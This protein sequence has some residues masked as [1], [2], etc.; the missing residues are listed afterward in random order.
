M[1]R[2]DG[3]ARSLA[4]EHAGAGWL[5]EPL[6]GG[7]TLSADQL[8]ECVENVSIAFFTLLE[9]LAPQA[10]AAFLTREVFGAG[11][12]EI[13]VALGKSETACRQLV[14]RARLQLR[15]RRAR[16]ALSK[17]A[18][19][20]LLRD[21]AS[22]S[23]HA[24]LATLKSMLAEDAEL[25][26]D[27]GRKAP[28]LGKPLQGGERIAQLYLAAGR[29]HGNALRTR[30]APINGEWGFLRFIDG[31]LESVQS[32]ETDGTRIVRI[33][34]QRDPGKLARLASILKNR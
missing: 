1:R 23:E 33:R 30:L 4:R 6:A 20:R 8:L 26:G 12:G 19:L 10:R 18:H 14:R 28:G 2:T 29:R 22:A 11:Y 5:A 15:E 25:I 31:V 34:V 27:D 7:S 17:E 24:D 3:S 21:F 32:L 9:G 13:A 16:F